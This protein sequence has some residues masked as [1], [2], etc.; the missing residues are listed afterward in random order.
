[1][2]WTR[3]SL[4]GSRLRSCAGA[5]VRL[6]DLGLELDDI[7]AAHARRNAFDHHAAAE[8]HDQHVARLRA[9]DDRERRQPEFAAEARHRAGAVHQ[10]FGQAVGAQ[11]Q[12]AVLRQHHHAR[13]AA[14]VVI[15]H[16]S[17]GSDVERRGHQQLHGRLPAEKNAQPATATPLETA[18]ARMR[19]TGSEQPQRQRCRVRHW[20]T[21]RRGSRLRT[22]SA[23]IS[24]NPA[25][26]EPAIAP[27]VFH[28]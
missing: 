14:D 3:G 2:T 27:T 10:R 11:G 7:D 16:A 4:S 18:I 9:R 13:A 17:I 28:A 20:R 15:E 23:G 24:T 5:P 12:A 8:S 6:D 1:M 19:L 22:C 25:A 21:P 26:S